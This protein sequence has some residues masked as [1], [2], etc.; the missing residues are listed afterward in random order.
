VLC[1]MYNVLYPVDFKQ[2]LGGKRMNSQEL[3]LV[4]DWDDYA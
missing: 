4:S 1:A 2:R 3:T